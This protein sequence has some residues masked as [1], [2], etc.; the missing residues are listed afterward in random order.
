MPIL[1]HCAL[2]PRS[3]WAHFNKAWWGAR[4]EFTFGAS[5]AQCLYNLRQRCTAMVLVWNELQV[6]YFN[7][8]NVVAD[9]DIAG[10]AKDFYYTLQRRCQQNRSQRRKDELKMD[11]SVIQKSKGRQ[12]KR[13]SKTPAFGQTDLVKKSLST[14]VTPPPRPSSSKL[15][16]LSSSSPLPVMSL[17]PMIDSRTSMAELLQLTSTATTSIFNKAIHQLELTDKNGCAH[18]NLNAFHQ[19]LQHLINHLPGTI[20]ID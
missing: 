12:K 6:R 5:D 2:G 1:K 7:S 20:E 13:S 11:P 3:L 10:F 18:F 17:R 4:Y 15:T 14:S 19:P 8:A 9:D 16:S